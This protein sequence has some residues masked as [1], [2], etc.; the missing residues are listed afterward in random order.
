M[1]LLCLLTKNQVLCI[2]EYQCIV[3]CVS[4]RTGTIL[5]MCTVMS[6]VW[7][8][9]KRYFKFSMCTSGIGELMG[10]CMLR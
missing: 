2:G 1:D 9:R 5:N 3:S 6:G 8:V 10:F 7:C 4:T